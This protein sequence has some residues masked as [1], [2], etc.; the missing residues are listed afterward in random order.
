M[1]IEPTIF[2]GSRFLSL[3]CDGKGSQVNWVQGL[4]YFAC[5][6]DTVNRQIEEDSIT[7][8]IHIFHTCRLNKI[9]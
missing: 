7:V 9:T 5:I 2:V 4:E 3:V 6:F 8:Y 1:G